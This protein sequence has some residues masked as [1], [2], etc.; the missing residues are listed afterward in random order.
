[1][2]YRSNFSNQISMN[3]SFELLSDRKKKVVLNSWAKG[4]AEVVFPAIDSD[5]FKVLY[6]DNPASRPAT[7]ASFVVGA[8]L[9]KEMIGLTDDEVVE[10]IQCDV[11]AQ[12]ALH[13]T[14]LEEQPISDRTLSRF[15]E[16]LYNYEQE[17][18][19]DLLHDEMKR[20]SD[21]FCKYLGIN[22]KLKRMDSLMVSTHA[23]A[24]SR[25]EIIYTTVSRCVTL[26]DKNNRNDLI[27]ED[28]KHYLE[29]DDL[30]NVIYY[31]KNEDVN[32]RLQKVIDEAYRMKDIMSSDEWYDTTEYQ[33]L[34]RV[35]K[36]QSDDN[37]KPKNKKDIRSDSMQNPN[38]TDATYRKKA[39]K[40]H[41]GYVGN[42]IEAVGENGASQIVDFTY[43]KN[44]HADQDFSREYIENNSDETM[45]ADGAYGSV[46][47]QEM[48]EEKNIQLV[49]TCLTGKDPD[50]VFSE[51]KLNEEG[52]EV[53]TCAQGHTPISST[54]YENTDLIRMKM[55]LDHCSTCPMREHCQA[56][57]QKK[58]AV[59]V[60]SKKMIA[61]AEYLKK[62]GTEE[63]K[64]LTR[65][66]NAVEGIMSVLRRRYRVDEIPVFGKDRS[67]QFFYLKVGAFN[68]VKLLKHM[69]K[70]AQMQEG[71]AI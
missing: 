64:A 29:S 7:P 9:I 47:L 33:L 51:Y 46:E 22:K 39:G 37:G 52:T 55:S 43:D 6:K 45:I 23:K 53:V 68:V 34:I 71:Y 48:A 70:T 1:M 49:T 60:V 19:I 18:G 38:D 25:L 40:D 28:M 56:K 63:Y 17:T 36:E 26:L 61:R 11:R 35:L 50:P 57:M 16:R 27:P 3:D 59:V 65:Q 58:E 54:Y 42:I 13:T 4:F 20:L 31:A 32:P 2:A 10:M 21:V 5:A 15:R 66:R 44:T 62:L 24:M 67:K 30:N 41:K 69:G 8:L 14:S 12:Y